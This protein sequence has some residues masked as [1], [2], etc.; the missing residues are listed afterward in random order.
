M[1][2]AEVYREQDRPKPHHGTLLVVAV[3]L[4]AIV[5]AVGI[6]Y[7][8][9]PRGHGDAPPPSTP[10]AVQPAPAALITIPPGSDGPD[11]TYQELLEHLQARGLTVR[12]GS[13]RFGQLYMLTDSNDWATGA[14]GL[15]EHGVRYLHPDAVA[16]EKHATVE[17]AKAAADR[18]EQR[19]FT[20]GR[21]TFIGS[22]AGPTTLAKFQKAL[23]G[24][25]DHPADGPP[26]RWPADQPNG[27]PP[28]A[29]P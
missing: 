29:K 1:D 22:R 5:A 10:A 3:P 14:A 19:T 26:D 18:H 7:F 4:A 13:S 8:L 17:E 2:E 12:M 11:W 21:F 28:K 23:T 6:G 16:C 27:P 15:L 25:S 20:W 9:W 24:Q